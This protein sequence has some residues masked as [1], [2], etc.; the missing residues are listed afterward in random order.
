MAHLFIYNNYY[1]YK[2]E[3]KQSNSCQEGQKKIT[4]KFTSYGAN[5]TKEEKILKVKHKA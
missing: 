1:Y 3:K 4:K 5:I 2:V